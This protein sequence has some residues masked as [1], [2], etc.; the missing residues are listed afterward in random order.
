MQL[1]LILRLKIYKSANSKFVGRSVWNSK[2]FIAVPIEVI[3]FKIHF[4]IT[5]INKTSMTFTLCAY[6]ETLEVFVDVFFSILT[7][8]VGSF[9]PPSGIQIVLRKSL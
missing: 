5:K 4:G 9:A 6:T 1:R 7:H 2:H 8:D 3:Y